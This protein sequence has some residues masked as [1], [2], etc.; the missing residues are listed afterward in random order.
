M[1][2]AIHDTARRFMAYDPRNRQTKLQS[3][4]GE[5]AYF[6]YSSADQPIERLLAN[7]VELTATYDHAG[8]LIARRYA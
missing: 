2:I 3:P 7:G 6:A 8:R 1:A 4:S 5:T